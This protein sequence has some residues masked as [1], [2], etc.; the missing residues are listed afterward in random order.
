LQQLVNELAAE[1]R[2]LRG[3]NEALANELRMLKERQRALYLDIDRRL[4]AMEAGAAPVGAA[5]PPATPAAPVAPAAAAVPGTGPAPAQPPAA[6]APA[7]GVPAQQERDA[8]KEALDLLREGRFERSIAAFRGFLQRF[9]KSGYADNAQYWLGEAHYGSKD[10]PNAA[11]EFAR[12]LSAYPGSGKAAD[13]QLKLGFTH[14][15]LG[16]WAAARSALEAVVSAYPGSTQARLAEQRLK[17][18]RQEGR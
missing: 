2:Q 8:Y 11:T 15:E 18:M 16:D 6:A 17:R 1:Q 4:Q 14:Y 12:V 5:E 10:Y 7:P 13:A 9:P 3:E